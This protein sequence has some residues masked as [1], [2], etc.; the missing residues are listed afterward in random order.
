[1]RLSIFWV[2]VICCLVFSIWLMWHTFSFDSKNSG[3]L[4]SDKVWSD[5]A[6]HMP[7]IRSFS[8]GQNWPPENPMFP[9]EK[10]RYHFLFFLI[11]GVLERI[12]LRIDWAINIPSVLGFWGLLLMIFVWGR[13]VYKSVGVGILAIIL[14]L[15]NG[16]MS[17]VTY[18]AN[19]GLSVVSVQ[20]ILTNSK[21]P[22]FGPWDGGKIAAIWNLN[23]YTNQRHLAPGIALALLAIYL[24][25]FKKTNP[26]ILG[27]ILG[28]L[29][30][31][32]EAIFAGL[33]I[34]FIWHFLFHL[35]DWKYLLLVAISIL[36]WFGLSRILINAGY[37]VSFKPGF[38]MTDSLTVVNFIKFWWA[39]LGLYLVLF[40]LSLFFVPK[41]Y[42][43]LFLPIATLF[44]IVNLFQLSPDMFNNH[45]LLNLNM[46]FMVIFVSG[47]LH[48]LWQRK[49]TRLFVP[50]LVL[51][52]VF[53]GVVDFFALR[54]DHKLTLTDSPKNP[55]ISFVET[56]IPTKAVV[57]NSTWLNH[58]ASLAGRPIYNGYTYFTWSHGY[59]SY[60]R[61]TVLKQIYM[62]TDKNLACQLLKDN[63]ISFVELNDHPEEYLHP[64]FLLWENEF[65]KI[66]NNPQSGVNYYD[67]EK[68]CP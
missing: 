10:I 6:G 26:L 4:V 24:V 58:S 52:L 53:S 55:E 49:I 41:A 35:K 64:N 11:A 28:I 68:S 43:Y 22:N 54:N 36:P 1:M 59:D 8:K 30:F 37:D 66:Y 5:F 2:V 31:L 50:L 34:Y 67:V 18:F 16:S 56:Y 15:F 17:F 25:N 51:F 39:N 3:M 13:K 21:Y 20:E 60:G 7:L 42:R 29:I 45:K 32:N 65:V 19:H 47:L 14:F 27:C 63:G 33:A 44:L 61:E 48:A 46:G 62:A 9:G 57:L 12:G 38:L 23:L 40:P